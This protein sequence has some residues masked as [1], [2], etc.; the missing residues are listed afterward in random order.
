MQQHLSKHRAWLDERRTCKRDFNFI[1]ENP[2]IRD[3]QPPG[4]LR[5][6]KNFNLFILNDMSPFSARK[7]K[8]PESDNQ[9]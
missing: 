4:G 8:C 3:W 2:T 1:T 9:N 5:G 6:N 7:N